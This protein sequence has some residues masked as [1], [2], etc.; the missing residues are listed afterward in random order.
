MLPAHVRPLVSVLPQAT[1]GKL[2]TMLYGMA[3]I[4]FIIAAIIAILGVHGVTLTDIAA[5]ISIGLALVSLGLALGPA[6]WWPG[7]RRIGP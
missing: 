4:T 1:Q 6:P 7:G 3:V 2:T 5:I